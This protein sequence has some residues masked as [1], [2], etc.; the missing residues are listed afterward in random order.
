MYIHTGR[1]DMT[2]SD[3]E[4]LRKIGIEPCLL[5]DPFPSSLPPP[6]PPRPVIPALS[7]KDACWLLNLGVMWDQD[8]ERDFVPPS[9][10]REYL[11][12]FPNGVRLAAEAATKEV[13]LDL[14][15]DDLD[16]LAQD[17]IVMSLDFAVS[18]LEDIVEMYAFHQPVLPGDHRAAHFHE[19]IRLRVLSIVLAMHESKPTGR[20][21]FRESL[22]F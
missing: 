13:G 6:P 8:T 17:I 2:S 12:R 19:Y 3:K 5:N 9:T 11:V 4:F 22:W 14:S 7:E 1:E 10:L 15:D 16:D 20:D 18:G 21:D